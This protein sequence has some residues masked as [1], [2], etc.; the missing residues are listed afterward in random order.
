M[1]FCRVSDFTRPRGRVFASPERAGGYTVVELVMVMLV[2]GILMANAMPRFFETSRFEEM[3]Y[4]DTVQGAIRHARRLAVASRCDTR[5]RVNAS[6]YA[7]SQRARE[8]LD[9]PAPA[10]PSGP[11]TEDV[12]RSNGQPWSD[13][14]PGG[15]TVGD[16]DI[17]FNAWGSPH[18]AGSGSPLATSASLA[19]GTRTVILEPVSGYVHA[20]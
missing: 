17:F 11:F 13:A 19:V 3:G 10:C 16:L 1:P 4:A 5:V 6:G 9:P 2:L 7:L 8:P 12:F 15:V 18:D 14:A 20:G